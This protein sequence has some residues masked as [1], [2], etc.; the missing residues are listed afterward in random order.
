MMECFV[1]EIL[2]LP[3]VSACGAAQLCADI[4]YVCNVLSALD[5]PASADLAQANQL[6]A[7]PLPDFAASVA[8]LSPRADLASRIS[9]IRNAGV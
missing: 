9:A 1:A 8:V 6:F 2:S 5:V 3:R 7:V 4:E